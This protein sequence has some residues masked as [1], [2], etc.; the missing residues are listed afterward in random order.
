MIH[1]SVKALAKLSGVSVRTLH[2]YDKINLLKPSS[3]TEAKYRMYGEAEL[4]R[5]QQILFYKELDFK[6]QEIQSILDDPK[7]DVQKALK[8]HKMLLKAKK[9]RIN[10]LLVTIDKTIISLNNGNIMSN[11]QDLYEGL[12]PESKQYREEAINKY[13]RKTIERSEDALLKMGKDGLEKLKS[14]SQAIWTQ[15]F[16]MRDKDPLSSEVQEVIAQHYQIIRQFWGTSNLEDTQA[17]AY[18]GLGQLYVDD[19]RFTTIDGQPH[20]DF[21]QFLNQA[22]KHFAKKF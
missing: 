16:T 3:R 9:G 13:G 18:A 6:L 1:Y 2:H 20:P 4:L 8:S 22:M 5:L 21:A 11:P 7:F 15:L 10:E 12:S 17:E 14:D 19:P